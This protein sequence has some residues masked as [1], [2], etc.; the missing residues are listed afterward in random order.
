MHDIDDYP[1]AKPV[2]GLVVYRYDAPL[3]FANAE[4][5]RSERWRLSRRVRRRS[6]GSCSTARPTS[7]ST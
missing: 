2:P 1:E 6:S 4:D 3:C 7:K 5:F